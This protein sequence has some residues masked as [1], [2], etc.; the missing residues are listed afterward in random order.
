MNYQEIW[1]RRWDAL[2]Q[3]MDDYWSDSSPAPT[4]QQD[5]SRL[6]TLRDI[7]RCLRIFAERQF[8]F[9]YDGFSSSS[10]ERSKEYPPEHA[11][12]VTLDQI[13]H[14][15]DVIQRA[16]WQR[17]SG[18]D[19]THETLVT[20][21]KLAW[22]SLQPAIEA[23]LVQEGSTVFTYFQK[24][25]SIRVIPYAPVAFIGIPFT[26]TD[27]PED[28]LAIPHEV[29]HYI[30]Q[31]GQVG[32][33]SI[34]ASLNHVPKG[35]S[36]CSRW[37]EE[38][39]A[40]V[41]GCLIGGPVIALDFQDIQLTSSLEQFTRDDGE[42]PTPV[43]RPSIYTKATGKR[44]TPQWGRKLDKH[45]QQASAHYGDLHEFTLC[46]GHSKLIEKAVS[47][48]P[49]LADE[50]V[51]PMDIAIVEVLER[52]VK[53]KKIDWWH[54]YLENST[55]VDTLYPAF[56]NHLTSLAADLPSSLTCIELDE[57]Y[58]EWLDEGE[59]ARDNCLSQ[60]KSSDEVPP[61][62]LPVLRAGGWATKGPQVRWH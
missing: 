33:T 51:E 61:V 28:Y 48:G 11:L 16:I 25:P 6:E 52:L 10:L 32:K 24:S 20:A 41:Y 38:I 43:L 34:Q 44:F 45:W 53:V 18:S 4:G 9:F 40:D 55:R 13:A 1:E 27:V 31:H 56:A 22:L 21:D 57:L 54:G 35:S 36:W 26:C 37:I 49:D 3:N 19:K 42:H 12:Y 14:D 62:W 60:G 7:T 50:P 30:F 46:N 2:R 15:F 23:G 58:Q 39:F 47:A 29:G 59:A 5:G 17:S 8:R